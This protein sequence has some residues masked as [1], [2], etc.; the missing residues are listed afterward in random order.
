[1]QL[2]TTTELRTKSSHLVDLLS[3]GTSVHLVHRS[4]IIGKISP[5]KAEGK[6][7]DAKRVLKIVTKMNLPKLSYEE[8]DRRYREAMM[9]KHGQS[10]S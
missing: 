4:K 8:R 7:F 9:K 6:I 2:I 10:L 3:S 5:Q 1:M